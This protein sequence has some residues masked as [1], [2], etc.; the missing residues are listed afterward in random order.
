M[1]KAIATHS[2]TNEIMEKYGLFTKKM[3]GQNF[4]IEPKI[5]EKIAQNSML[6]ESTAVIEIGP[7]IGA[8][9]EQLAKIAKTVWAYEIDTRLI[10]ILKADTLVDYNNIQIIHQDFL[11]TDIQEVVNTLKQTH[12]KVVVAANLPYYITTPI[13][14]KLFESE[15]DISYITVMMQKEVADRFSASVNTKDYNALSV[16]VQY[17]YNVK[18]VMKIPKT[19]FHPKPN[20]DSSVVQFNKKDEVILVQDKQEFFDMV[21]GCFKQRRKTILNNYSTYLNDKIKASAI[22]A[23]AMI[24]PVRRAESMTVEEFIH[25]Y[26]VQYEK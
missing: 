21:K 12:Q 25:L 1:K 8:L 15:V 10:E 17:N 20:V 6:D 26:E 2:R 9:T 13:L 14:F 11:E 16:I 18:Q 3:Y 24:D 4:I 22:L 5:V 19:I 23:K 7:G